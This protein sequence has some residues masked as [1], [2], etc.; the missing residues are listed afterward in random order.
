MHYGSGT[1][2]I[3]VIGQLQDAAGACSG[4]L[5]SVL[6]RWPPS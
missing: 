2:H 1:E 3:I 4:D 5:V 6:T